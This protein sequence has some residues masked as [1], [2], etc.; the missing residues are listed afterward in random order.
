[1]S[2]SRALEQHYRKQQQARRDGKR[3]CQKHFFF[4]HAPRSVK[5][6]MRGA[7]STTPRTEGVPV[8]E[9]HHTSHW[10]VPVAEEGVLLY[11]FF[12]AEL[13]VLRARGVT[14]PLKGAP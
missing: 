9:V 10:G 12:F 5:G 8:A 1:M 2:H 13:T 6:P 11:G 4:L 7:W 3:T 14:G